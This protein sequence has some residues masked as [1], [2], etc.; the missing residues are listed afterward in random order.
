M[1]E[2]KAR[3]CGKWFGAL[4]GT[5]DS[6]RQWLLEKRSDCAGND[7]NPLRTTILLAK[8]NGFDHESAVKKQCP[9]F[10]LPEKF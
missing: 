1:V 9:R 6:V 5:F 3:R 7:T 10:V 2:E 8:R 4:E